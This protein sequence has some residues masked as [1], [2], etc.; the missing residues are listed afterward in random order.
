MNDP[1][2]KKLFDDDKTSI[3]NV[4]FGD[5]IAKLPFKF[6]VEALVTTVYLPVLCTSGGSRILYFYF[7]AIYILL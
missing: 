4:E 5:R 3:N 2:W 6:P 7:Y 1:D